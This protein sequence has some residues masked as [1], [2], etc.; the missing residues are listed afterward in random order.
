MAGVIRT[1]Q[2]CPKCKKS[3][4]SSKGGSPIICSACLTQ[5]NKFYIKLPWGGESHSLYCDRQGKPMRDFHHA[6]GVLGEI[7]AQLDRKNFDPNVYK[8]QSKTG[9]L[10]FWDRFLEGYEDRRGSYDKIRAIGKHHLTC[11]YELQ[12]RDITTLHIDDWWQSKR[13]LSPRYR[14]D[15]LTWLKKFFNDALRLDIIEKLPHF[16]IAVDVPE[17]DIIDYLTEDEQL[18]VLDRL[19]SYDRAIF[20]FLFLTGIRVNEATGLLRSDTDWKREITII[21][22]TI[23]RDGSIG[24]VKNKKKRIIPHVPE[25]RECLIRAMK[26]TG[27]HIEHQFINR[28]RRRYSDDYLRDTFKKACIKTGVEPIHLKNATRHSFGMGLLRKGFDIWQ[29]SKAMNH[30]GIGMTE[31]YVQLLTNEMGGMYGRGSGQSR[32]KTRIRS[33]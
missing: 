16:P 29:T 28:W 2:K 21:Q 15:C 19:P 32:D 12:M 4:P 31:H 3:F 25:I 8:K 30:S 9:F 11:F 6:V 1:Y 17:P 5:P 24:I 26:I 20:D 33:R 13:E 18:A 27:L 22:H 7:R 23:K 14:N 10:A